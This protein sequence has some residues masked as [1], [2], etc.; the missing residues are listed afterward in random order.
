MTPPTEL[1]TP[2]PPLVSVLVRSLDREY[3]DEALASVAAQTYP[4]IELVVVAAQPGHRALPATL[5]GR[6]LRLL[7]TPQARPRSQAA[8]VALDAAQ[9]QYLLFLDDDD[10]LMPGHIERLVAVLQQHPDARAAYTGIAMV[11]SAGRPHGQAFDTAFD[12][13]RQLAGNL[14][15][16]H[17]VLFDA[18]LVAA[19]GCRFDETLDRYEDW[20]F[21]IQLARQTVF[22]HLPGVSGIYRIHDSSGV[23]AESGPQAEAS[24]RVYASWQ[25]RWT[26]QQLSAIMQR[27]WSYTELHTEHEQTRQQLQATEAARAEGDHSV[28]LLTQELHLQRQA[29]Q[30]LAQ[31]MEAARGELQALRLTTQAQ[32]DAAQR[33]S[34]TLAEQQQLLAGQQQQLA[35]QQQ[36]L[37]QQSHRIESL[38]HERAALLG[39]TSWRVTAPL[40]WLA[41]LVGGRKPTGGR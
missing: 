18:R 20:D 36:T 2:A 17:A 12:A 4:A 34:Q 27:V 6:P 33:L 31:A 28:A 23:H 32:A 19:G 37:Q 40:R 5:G 25:A 26:P 10:W 7:D 9:G 8:N 39:S 41:G 30:V 21:W 29:Q 13:V 11:D 35:G 24:R 3:L 16:I 1:A 14:T 15:P 22:V 38:Q